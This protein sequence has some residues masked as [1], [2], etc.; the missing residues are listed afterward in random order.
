MK[1]VSF[2]DILLKKIEALEAP[3]P[4]PPAQPIRFESNLEFTIFDLPQRVFKT[5]PPKVQKAKA[6]PK[7]TKPPTPPPPPETVYLKKSL[8]D[9]EQS[10]WN[11]FEKVFET[12]LG[13]QTTKSQVMKSFRR[14]LKKNHPDLNHKT[15]QH[16]FATLVKIKDELIR[17]LK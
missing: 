5:P 11:L 12:Q 8:N 10:Q 3:R 9:V 4:T 16:N 1:T 13:E 6:P 7:A 17:A 15:T 14:F 2:H